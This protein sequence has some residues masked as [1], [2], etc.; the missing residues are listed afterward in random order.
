MLV[1]NRQPR[2]PHVKISRVAAV[3]PRGYSKFSCFIA[4]WSSFNISFDIIETDT[5]IKEKNAEKNLICEIG[6]KIAV[7]DVGMRTI[8]QIFFQDV[9]DDNDHFCL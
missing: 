7:D 8:V 1:K 9:S 6:P 5:K 3:T 4:K 2:F